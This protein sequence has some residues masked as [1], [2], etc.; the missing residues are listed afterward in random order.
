MA[1][2]ARNKT[3]LQFAMEDALAAMQK[4]GQASGNAKAVNYW[5]HDL[6]RQFERYGFADV[7]AAY[8]K[9]ARRRDAYS[10]IDGCITWLQYLPLAQARNQSQD[11]L[12]LWLAELHQCALRHWRSELKRMA[13]ITMAA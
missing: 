2:S 5:L 7:Q 11:L 10:V 9:A 4:S 13:A 1:T 3:N 12:A 6:Q 8:W